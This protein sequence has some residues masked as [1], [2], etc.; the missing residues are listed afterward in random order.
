MPGDS[1]LTGEDVIAAVRDG[2][3]L[4]VGTDPG[5]VAVVE[6]LRLERSTDQ[7]GNGHDAWLKSAIELSALPEN[8]EPQA[9]S[10]LVKAAE[11]IRQIRANAEAVASEKR[12]R[13]WQSTLDAAL[14]GA[15]SP[16]QPAAELP[17]ELAKMNSAL[18]ELRRNAEHSGA[19]TAIAALVE[20]LAG[21]DS[22]DALA[23]K[24]DVAWGAVGKQAEAIAAA[25]QKNEARARENE[26]QAAVREFSE[27]WHSWMDTG[28]WQEANTKMSSY[29]RRR[30]ESK[31]LDDL[32]GRALA[33]TYR[34]VRW[35][36][37][38]LLGL[39][40]VS[41]AGLVSWH[42]FGNPVHPTL[43]KT[44]ESFGVPF[45]G[46][47][48]L[49]PLDALCHSVVVMLAFVLGTSLSQYSPLRVGASRESFRTT[50]IAIFAAVLLAELLQLVVPIV[51]PMHARAWMH[52]LAAELVK[53]SVELTKSGIALLPFVGIALVVWHF[54]KPLID[55]FLS[56]DHI[57]AFGV[58]V[59]FSDEKRLAVPIRDFGTLMTALA[60]LIRE[61]PPQEK[62]RF[63]AYTP[64]LGYLM[65]PE[66]EWTELSS[67]MDARRHSIDLVCLDKDALQD[68]HR[69][70][71]GRVGA[72]GTISE[73]QTKEATKI[74]EEFLTFSKAKRYRQSELPTYYLFSRGGWDPVAIIVVPFG[75]PLGLWEPGSETT[76][77]Q[78]EMVGVASNDPSVLVKVQRLHDFY[79]NGR[80]K[81][82]ESLPRWT[83]RSLTEIT[84]DMLRLSRTI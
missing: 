58:E 62:I 75:L 34:A 2:Q 17:T 54:R 63:L 20:W 29:R 31:L 22:E 82:Q 26:C 25:R 33:R 56:T 68:W 46:V 39:F 79:S 36:A 35:Y 67:A 76:G 70:F 5:I 48:T 9:S 40:V 65:R 73:D 52:Q 45:A 32:S 38:G 60:K 11:S 59:N 41:A 51:N 37:A 6:S 80:Q 27:T 10:D 74:S 13:L 1:R 19:E 8:R 47:L 78:V 57:E 66:E 43:G 69:Q 16:T 14:T 18:A 30:L 55:K 72:K 44:L 81:A 15:G 64:A 23:S 84:K 83:W 4:P 24:K 50:A 77:A 42:A 49:G 21:D 3:P 53:G 28:R 7:S 12:D 61:A 71:E